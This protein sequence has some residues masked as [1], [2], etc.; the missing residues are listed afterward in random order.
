MRECVCERERDERQ[1]KRQ[2]ERKRDRETKTEK[3]NIEIKKAV[4]E[5]D[6]ARSKDLKMHVTENNDEMSSIEKPRSSSSPTNKTKDVKTLQQM[7]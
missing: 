1:R 6:E 4:E 5:A 2:R 7:E 3:M